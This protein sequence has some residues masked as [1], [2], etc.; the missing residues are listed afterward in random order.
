MRFRIGLH[1]GY[2][3]PPDALS[4]LAEALGPVHDDAR[5]ALRG[6]GELEATWGED[7]PTAM[8]RDEREEIGRRALLELIEEA[9]ERT[10]GL[11]L[12]WFAVRPTDW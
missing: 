8:A 12:D 1:A 11:R 4:R 7:A 10:P 2:G 6:E 9:C 5:F 3:A